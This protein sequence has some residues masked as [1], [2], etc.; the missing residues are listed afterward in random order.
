MK[1][2]Q[3]RT[4]GLNDFEEKLNRFFEQHRESDLLTITSFGSIAELESVKG[5]MKSPVV[6]S[7]YYIEPNKAVMA[8]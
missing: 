1:E 7:I 5:Q 6:I 3:I 4:F 8:D 2:Y